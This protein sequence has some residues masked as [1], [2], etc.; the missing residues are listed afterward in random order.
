MVTIRDVAQRAGVAVSTVSHALSGNRPV[1]EETRA[2]VFAAIAELGYHPNRRAQSLVTGRARTIGIL[3]PMESSGNGVLNMTQLEMIVE[4]SILA[5]ANGYSLQLYTQADDESTLKLLCHLCDG[6]LVSMVR[7]HDERVDYLVKQD[8]PFVLLGHPMKADDVAWVDTDFADMIMQQLTHLV[9]LGHRNII[10]LDRPA[11]LLELKLGY[12]VRAR[13]GYLDA[14]ATLNINP[15]IISCELSIEDGRR[16]LH[17][18][19]QQYPSVTALAAF[20][21][22]AAVGTYYG[23]LECGKRIPADFS[24]ITFTTRGYLQSTV[25][26]MTAMLNTGPVVSKTATEILLNMLKDEPLVGNQMLIKSSLIP[27]QTTGPVRVH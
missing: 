27:G 8:Y 6:L 4:S 2:R 7:L 11:R 9:E 16:V 18:I 20:N 26:N 5:Q 13:Q 12:T 23:L 17:E 24:I 10:F 25:P 1:N 21:D 14:C 3:F 22:A 15:L 19:L